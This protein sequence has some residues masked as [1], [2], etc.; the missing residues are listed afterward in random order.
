MLTLLVFMIGAS[1]AEATQVL[2]LIAVVGRLGRQ[3]MLWNGKIFELRQ[4]PEGKRTQA[5]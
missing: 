3:I 5:W 4:N 1:G 2:G